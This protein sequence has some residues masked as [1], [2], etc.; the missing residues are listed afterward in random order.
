VMFLLFLVRSADDPSTGLLTWKDAERESPWNA[1][2]LVTGAV[3]MTDAL[4]QFGF[5]EFMGNIVRNLGITPTA[6]PY[7]AAW[8]TAVTTNFMSGTAT[9]ALF[10]NFFIP[11][12][13][14]IGYNPASMAILIA[15]VALGMVV[16]WAGA[17]AV[18]TFTGGE[19]EI[20]QMIR[21]GIV[22]TIIYTTVA[23]TIHLMM[24]SVI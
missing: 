17:T 7:V 24:S 21:V 11:A 1:M 20:K 9:A 8:S 10:C 14:Q 12:A 6:L 18:T 2:L 13:V 16:P 5:V 15:N 23:A 4:A 19:I 22:A 3:A